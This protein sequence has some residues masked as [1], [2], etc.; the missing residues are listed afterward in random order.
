MRGASATSF[1]SDDGPYNLG[2][3]WYSKI[4]SDGKPYYCPSNAKNDNLVYE[5]YTVLGAWPFGFDSASPLQTT[6]NLVRAEYICYPQ[7]TTLVT[8]ATVGA[9]SQDIP[10][11]PAYNSTGA[12]NPY[13]TW[14]CA[15]QFKQ[16]KIDQKKSMIVDVMNSGLDQLSHRNGGSS[17]GVNAAFGDGHVICKA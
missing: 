11:W 7:S 3:L 16:S 5:F 13:K 8:T 9:G 15:P 2:I 6:A 17:A 10:E 12:V 1:D 14:I 4:I